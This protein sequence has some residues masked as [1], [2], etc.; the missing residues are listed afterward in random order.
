MAVRGVDDHDVDPGVE[1]RLGALELGV[2]GA[3]GRGDAQ[4]AV[5][6]LAALGKSCAFSM[7]LTVMRPVQR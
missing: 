3:G 7:S 5:L 1:Q 6:V 2:A 4:P